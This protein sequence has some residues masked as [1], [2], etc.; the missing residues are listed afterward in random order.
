MKR[1]LSALSPSAA[2]IVVVSLSAGACGNGDDETASTSAERACGRVIDAACAKLVECKAS[3]QG[4]AVTSVVC[5]SIR[6]GAISNCLTDEGPALA[7]A[8]EA[9]VQSCVDGFRQQPC[10]EIC[11][12]VPQDPA[13]CQKFSLDPNKDFISCT[14]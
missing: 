4:K 9:D 11:N 2:A 3:I 12:Q 7:A 1:R 8:S 10:S 13:A 6:T 5:A 14:P